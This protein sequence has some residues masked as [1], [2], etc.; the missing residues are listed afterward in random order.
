MTMRI[1]HVRAHTVEH[2]DRTI[3]PPRLPGIGYE[4]GLAEFGLPK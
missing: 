4:A 2:P 1:V 3:R